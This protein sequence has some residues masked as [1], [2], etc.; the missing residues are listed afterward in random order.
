MKI[1]LLCEGNAET[2][3]SWSGVSQSVVRQLRSVGHTVVTGDVD[4]YGVERGLVAARTVHRQ[5]RRWWVRYHLGGAGFRARSAQAAR[6]IREL[7][8]GVDL[9]LQVGATFRIPDDVDLPVVLYCDSNIAHAHRG[10]DTGY[11]DAAVLTPAEIEEVRAREAGVYARASVVF[12]MSHAARASFIEDFHIPADRVITI[13]CGPN[14]DLV[15]DVQRGDSPGARPTVLFVGRDFGRKGGDLLLRAFPEVRRHVPDARLVVVGGRSSDVQPEWVEYRGY[16][17]RS[18]A[19]G[20]AGMDRAYR[21]ADVFCLP[22][23]FEAFGTSFVEA[24]FYGL[25][26][27]GP[28]AWAVP[29]IIAHGETGLVVP[30][31]DPPA[32]AGALVRLLS[33]P[34]AAR[35]MGSAARARAL[36]HFTWTDVVARMVQAME[37]LVAGPVPAASTNGRHQ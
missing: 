14:M 34:M 15:D 25:P 3:D 16:Q 13:H 22:T 23:R 26:C 36:E 9:I 10:A 7:G 18:T 33:D 21:E 37:P 6:R 30:P 24:M 28:G 27:V 5:R 35:R 29:E 2:T 11:S 1:L 31:E 12:S 8:A 20:L 4:L 17:N 32:L 19:G